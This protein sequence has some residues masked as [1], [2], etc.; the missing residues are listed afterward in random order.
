LPKAY[1]VAE[2]MMERRKIPFTDADRNILKRAME[3]D[4][5]E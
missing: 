3:I 5:F 4:G 2:R 1:E